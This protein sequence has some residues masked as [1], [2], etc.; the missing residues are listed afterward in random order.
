MKGKHTNDVRG[1]IQMIKTA[2]RVSQRFRI[3][4][5]FKFHVVYSVPIQNVMIALTLFD[6]VTI[7]LSV[8]S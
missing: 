5:C 4:C 7:R 1:K 8:V 6:C 3:C 2:A